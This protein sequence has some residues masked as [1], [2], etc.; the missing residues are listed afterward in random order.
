MN[1]WSPSF[2]RSARIFFTSSGDSEKK[3]T[4]R[5]VST[6]FFIC[7]QG[8]DSTL[9]YDGASV[10]PSLFFATFRRRLVLSK[11]GHSRNHAHSLLPFTTFTLCSNRTLSA[12]KRVNPHFT[13][14]F[15]YL[16]RSSP[17]AG[18]H[19]LFLHSA[20]TWQTNECPF[21]QRDPPQIKPKMHHAGLFF[22]FS[23]YI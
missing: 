6:A 13:P 22:V 5:C 11:S 15:P 8:C 3:Y 12:P 18:H 7:N 20:D 17:V 1:N 14:P 10:S 23:L 2:S 9:C 4:D 19:A 16:I 21:V